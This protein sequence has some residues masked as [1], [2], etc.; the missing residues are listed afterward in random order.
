[1]V[2]SIIKKGSADI[3]GLL[4]PDGRFI[5]IETKAPDGRLSAEQREFLE[6]I[7]QQSDL[8][9]VAKSY[10]DIETALREAGYAG[11]IAGTLFK[12]APEIRGID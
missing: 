3:I 2:L 1:V 12:E 9:V 4:P 5:A 7:K 8:T 6:M 11:I 10:R